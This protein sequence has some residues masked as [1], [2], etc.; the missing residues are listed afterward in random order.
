MSEQVRLVWGT[1]PEHGRVLCRAEAIGRTRCP[2]CYRNYS[3]RD[4]RAFLEHVAPY[5]AADWDAARGLSELRTCDTAFGRE[6]SPRRHRLA[7]CALARMYF[8][9]AKQ[10]WLWR[11]V[12]AGEQWADAGAAPPEAA[13]IFARVGSAFDRYNVGPSKPGDWTWLAA[14]CV[15]GDEEVTENDYYWGETRTYHHPAPPFAFAAG[16]E[17]VLAP[18]PA[19]VFRELAPN[20]FRPLNWNP[21]WLTP[22]VRAVAAQ[23]YESGEFT[24]LPILADALQDADCNDEQILGH[25]RGNRPH[26]RGCWVLDAILAKA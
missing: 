12:E 25:C 2:S 9:H 1:C 26:A 8:A 4:T 17:A 6:W 20:P 11:G 23:V 24:A 18:A 3:G 19:V 5:G 22:T 7:F 16:A 13:D 21:N 10:Y 15:C 14:A